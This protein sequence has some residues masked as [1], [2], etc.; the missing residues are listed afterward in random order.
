MCWNPNIVHWTT[1]TVCNVL[2]MIPLADS[3]TNGG[4]KHS[5]VVCMLVV[6]MGLEAVPE[7]QLEE[8]NQRVGEWSEESE[9]PHTQQFELFDWLDT[10]PSLA[11]PCPRMAPLHLRCQ[12]EA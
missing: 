9:L 10:P 5:S 11:P 6:F 4:W 2:L 8:P 3:K 1:G 7:S 12:V